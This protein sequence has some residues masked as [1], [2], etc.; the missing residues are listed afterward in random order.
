MA[1]KVKLLTKVEEGAKDKVYRLIK[2]K[3]PYVTIY[4]KS[5]K[6]RTLLAIDPQKQ[7]KREIR[8]S[9][10]HVSPWVDEQDGIPTIEPIQFQDG[11]LEVEKENVALINFLTVHPDRGVVFEEVD[12]E[13]DAKEQYDS[14]L[15][16]VD[17]LTEAKKLK[18]AELDLIGRIV[19]GDKAAGLSTYELKRDILIYAKSK[20]TS[21]LAA[22][23]DPNRTKRATVQ[24]F[25][26]ERLIAF[27]D[28]KQYVYYNLPDNKSRL[29]VLPPNSE[30]PMASVLSWFESDEGV[31]T[32]KHLEHLL[33]EGA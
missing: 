17:A 4:H 33:E 23:N 29:I 9:S 26:D 8:Y 20:P 11:M 25:F 30:D 13:R 32:Y 27:R 14:M 31:A 21:F 1:T 5:M 6:R 18:D 19:L 12:S 3:A 16:E 2:K 22:L 10:S 24:R 28:R 7:I 15:A